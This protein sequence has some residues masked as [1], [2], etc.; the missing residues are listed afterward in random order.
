[1][2]IRPILIVKCCFRLTL[3]HHWEGSDEM[4]DEADETNMRC[5]KNI[6]GSNVCWTST[7]A[8]FCLPPAT[9]QEDLQIIEFHSRLKELVSHVFHTLKLEV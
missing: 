1:M 6:R 5:A 9:S 3:S 4:I 2:C 8:L 7:L